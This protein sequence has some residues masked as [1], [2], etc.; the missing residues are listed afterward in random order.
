M[1]TYLACAVVGSLCAGGLPAHGADSQPVRVGIASVISDISIFIADKK[2][3]FRDE[4][5]TVTITPFTSGANMVAPLGA[6]R[7]HV[8]VKRKQPAVWQVYA[9]GEALEN[10]STWRC[11]TGAPIGARWL[12]TPGRW[13]LGF[14][15]PPRNRRCR[16][17]R[18]GT[19]F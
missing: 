5:L 1:R 13:R 4:G 7:P 14:M 2:G 19:R 9:K 3:Y 6:A 11:G 17:L 8:F 15:I 18:H 10:P 16:K 12:R